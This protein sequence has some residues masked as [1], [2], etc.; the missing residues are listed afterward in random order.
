MSEIRIALIGAG[1][2]G[3][4]HGRNFAAGIRGS[5]L[6]AIG[7]P[8]AEARRAARAELGDVLEFDDP[9]AAVTDDRVDAVVLAG[10]TRTHA[11]LAIAALA[12][13][14]HVLCEKPIASS[15]VQA[16][17]VRHAAA[18]SSGVFAMGFMRRFDA[19]FARLAERVRAGD[20]G[21]PILVKSTGRGPGLPPAWAWDTRTSGG[22][23][24]EVGSHDIDTVRWMSGQ[25]PVRVFAAGRA[26]KRPDLAREHPGFVDVL[27][28][29][30]ELSD[31]ALG[32]VDN[33][34]PAGYGYDA[35]IEV[36][37][38]EGV[39][40]AGSP[41]QPSPVLVTSAGAVRDPVVSWRDLFADAYR[42]EDGHFIACCRGEA[43][44]RASVDDGLAALMVVVA[45][46]ESLA[47]GTAVDVASAGAATGLDRI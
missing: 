4:V 41:E 34:C 2:A 26:A 6:V 11:P 23:I 1:R 27:T 16:A 31:G 9:I 22:L 46:N 18:A 38:S 44:P 24:A 40:L 15:P 28:V 14:K 8:S 13:G 19:R 45:V 36:Y 39:L 42:E 7:D 20:I 35:R 12:A 32:Q 43:E 33:A 21:Q 25:E 30:M 47:T 17:E 5:R 37:G 29:T 10:P 3:L